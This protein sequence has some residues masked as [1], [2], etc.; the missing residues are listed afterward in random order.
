[1]ITMKENFCYS[2]VKI[3]ES[4]CRCLSSV[5]K[6]SLFSDYCYLSANDY[7]KKILAL[8]PYTADF[9]ASPSVS[10]YPQSAN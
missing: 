2:A 9:Y 7:K 3:C 10:H 8:K 4:P 5:L 1:M 6:R